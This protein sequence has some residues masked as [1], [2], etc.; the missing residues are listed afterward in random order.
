MKTQLENQVKQK[1]DA[2]LTVRKKD[3]DQFF[4]DLTFIEIRKAAEDVRRA[5]FRSGYLGNG[6][7]MIG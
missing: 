6:V 4:D 3:K 7:N 1:K 5:T 2:E